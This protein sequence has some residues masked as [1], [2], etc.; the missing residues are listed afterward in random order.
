MGGGVEGVD[1]PGE[2]DDVTD[3]DDGYH[4]AG[5][6]CDVGISVGFTRRWSRSGSHVRARGA[7][8]CAHGAGVENAFASADAF[9]PAWVRGKLVLQL[10]KPRRDQLKQRRQ[11]HD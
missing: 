5:V 3:V 4:G 6:A 11:Q 7:G 8:L 9:G 1:Q 10:R 2:R